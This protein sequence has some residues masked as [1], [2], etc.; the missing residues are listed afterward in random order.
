MCKIPIEVIVTFAVRNTITNQL[1]IYSIHLKENDTRI[2]RLL[3][4]TNFLLKNSLVTCKH[5]T[6]VFKKKQTQ[7]KILLTKKKCAI[8]F[9]QLIEPCR[10]ICD[11][12]YKN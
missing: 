3:S 6:F 1:N 5:V 10:T 2:I 7:I 4:F 12:L 9:I 11:W 8:L